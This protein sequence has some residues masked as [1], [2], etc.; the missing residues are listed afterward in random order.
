MNPV[1]SCGNRVKSKYTNYSYA[2]M[3]HQIRSLE[4]ELK[5]SEERYK[6]LFDNIS[7]GVFQTDLEG[8]IIDINSAGV[9]IFGYKKSSE[10]I[11][12]CIFDIYSSFNDL[13]D[14]K[15]K[16]QNSG[17][18]IQRLSRYRKRDNSMVW[19]ETT[20]RCRYLNKKFIGFEGIYRDVTERIRYQEMLE[21][22]YSLWSDLTE[23]ESFE[24]IS[25]L[26][27]DFINAMLI[28]DLGSFKVVD[29]TNLHCIGDG[30][31]VAEPKTLPLMGPSVSARAVRT[32]SVQLI[33][34]ANEEIDHVPLTTRGEEIMSILAVPV[35][36]EDSPIAVIEIG[37]INP[38][39]FADEDQKLIEVITEYVAS[40]MNRIIQQKLSKR[41]DVKLSDFL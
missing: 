4:N 20:L 10:L 33:S 2:L 3:R 29:G 25:E 18:I 17:K 27:L 23:V 15:S 7:D 32:C 9:N 30:L 28:I 41:P 35:K 14:I 22:L 6:Q 34:N 36:I 40:A 38:A 16:V 37:S 1:R 39:Q 5:I 24:K 13:Y 21:A 26:T 11:G 12:S 8:K 31:G 19:L